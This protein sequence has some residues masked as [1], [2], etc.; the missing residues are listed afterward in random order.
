MNKPIDSK[1]KSL[2]IKYALNEWIYTKRILIIIIINRF[3][4]KTQLICS[5]AR[6]EVLY[7]CFG[8]WVCVEILVQVGG[9]HNSMITDTLHKTAKPG[10]F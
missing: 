2:C 5:F 8:G 6:G 4:F 1:F 10:H 9:A 7:L 3:F